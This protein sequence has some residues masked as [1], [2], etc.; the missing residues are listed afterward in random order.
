MKWKKDEAKRRP[1]P[2]AP[3]PGGDSAQSPPRSPEATPSKAE[4]GGDGEGGQAGSHALT[5]PVTAVVKADPEGQGEDV[6]RP[7]DRLGEEGL[8]REVASLL[9]S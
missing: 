3:P 1:R 5:S 7:P 6:T 4:E 2:L 8:K 9:P